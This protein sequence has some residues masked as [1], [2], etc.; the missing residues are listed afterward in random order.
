[1]ARWFWDAELSGFGC[2]ANFAFLSTSRVSNKSAVWHASGDVKAEF[3]RR[4]RLL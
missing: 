2:S 3:R 1:M 4:L